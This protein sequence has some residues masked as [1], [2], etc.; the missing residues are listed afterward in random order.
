MCV[1]C[2]LARSA[3]LVHSADQNGVGVKPWTLDFGLNFELNFEL[4]YGLI[5]RLSL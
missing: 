2:T 1:V 5:F 3:W 4:D